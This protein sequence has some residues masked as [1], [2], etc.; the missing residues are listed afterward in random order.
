ML[1]VMSGPMSK[2][3]S[4][5]EETLAGLKAHGSPFEYFIFKYRRRLGLVFFLV[6]MLGGCIATWPPAK[7]VREARQSWGL[8][9][10]HAIG[11]ALYSYAQDHNGTYPEG[12]SST[13]VFQ[14]LIDGGYVTDPSV[15]YTPLSGKTKATGKVLK[16]ENVCWDFTAGTR[17]DDPSNVAVV[18]S[19]GTRM[20]YTPG[21]KI[22]VPRDSPFG[23]EGVAVFLSNE[24]AFFSS[25][26]NGET[27]IHRPENYNPKG[28]HYV[29]L[30]P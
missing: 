6:A 27:V 29:Q 28:Q 17:P 14:K 13:E 19:T 4:T 2:R 10:A 25:A 18:F 20:D 9:E 8:Q 22:R 3:H 30:T 7:C 12:N 26:E 21:A 24:A 23:A 16:A 5:S 11:V 15:F 1:V